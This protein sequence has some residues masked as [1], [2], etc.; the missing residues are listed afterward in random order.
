MLG[1]SVFRGQDV[2][3]HIASRKVGD[4][5]AT[6]LMKKDDV[7]AVN[8]VLFTELDAHPPPERLGVQNPLRHRLRCEEV[9]DRCRGQWALLPC[10][11]HRFCPF[12]RAI[13]SGRYDPLFW[14]T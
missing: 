9:P 10:Q 5:I 2:G 12:V 14:A 8:D 6:G 11:S 1:D 13:Y 3:L 7:L 4:R